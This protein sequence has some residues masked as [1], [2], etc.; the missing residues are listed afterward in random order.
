MPFRQF[1]PFKAGEFIVAGGDCSQGGLDKNCTQFISKT[2][3]DIPLV[4]HEHG[5]AAQMTS[6]LHPILE[7]IHDVTGVP[8]CIG[9]ERN[10]GGSSEMSR[11]EALNRLGKYTLFMMPK[12]GVELNDDD[13]DEDGNTNKFGWDTNAA[14]RPILLGDW[15]LAVRSKVIRIYDEETI[16]EHFYFIINSQGKPEAARK[17]H[18]DTVIAAAVAYQ[19]FQHVPTP[20]KKMSR[21]SLINQLPKETE[22]QGGFY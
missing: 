21:Q 12:F 11:L 19:I 8:P 7:E 17:K 4:Y 13:R 22:F 2:H 3:M 15:K 6:A 16:K 5:V 20:Q 10:M 18:D 14:T 9:L 1:R